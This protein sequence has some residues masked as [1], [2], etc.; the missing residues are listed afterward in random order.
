LTD[1]VYAMPKNA[2]S[3]VAVIAVIAAMMLGWIRG[4][5]AQTYNIGS[6][7]PPLSEFE[8]VWVGTIRSESVVEAYS[9][10]PLDPYQATWSADTRRLVIERAGEDYRVRWAS[11]TSQQVPS[12]RES[13]RV[14][15]DDG[16]C[17]KERA[18][19]GAG[20]ISESYLRMRADGQYLDGST[21]VSF[22][23]TICCF[24]Q[25][26]DAMT[27]TADTGY[28]L[29]AKPWYRGAWKVAL[30]REGGGSAPQNAI[31]GRPPPR[32]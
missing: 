17:L 1:V 20:S 4:A 10:R 21:P 26:R 5:A 8:G 15:S 30:T 32:R 16:R 11:V 23:S 24:L 9:T 2:P 13:V 18:R 12:L 14:E 28:Q 7:A 3:P 19:S 6:G 22:T 27:C 31:P 25:T 29:A